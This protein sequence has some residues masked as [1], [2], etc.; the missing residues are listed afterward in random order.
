MKNKY[1][2]LALPLTV[3]LVAVAFY[4]PDQLSRWQDESLLD[5]PQIFRSD[6]ALQDFAASI[7]LSIPEK[8]RLLRSRKLTPVE[9]PEEEREIRLT[10]DAKGNVSRS[11][12]PNLKESGAELS[13][14]ARA[15]AEKQE[16]TWRRRVTSARSE[17]RSLQKAGGIPLLWP[18][19]ALV[20]ADNYREFL[21][22]DTETQVTFLAYDMELSAA[23]FTLSLLVD[24]QTG[25]ILSFTA[26]VRGGQFAWEKGSGNFADAWRDYWYMDEVESTYAGTSIQEMLKPPPPQGN[27]AYSASA[28]VGYS[29]GGEIVRVPL[30]SRSTDA[31]RSLLWNE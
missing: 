30:F 10:L 19:D 5:T 15:E 12:A 4:L 21:Y 31:I 2:F 28:E 17:V 18:E 27:S 25:K 8:I 9:I 26:K 14:E 16:E 24:E 3:L 29:Y 20:T 13:E 1:L 22:I 23:N 6:D 7:R 11:E